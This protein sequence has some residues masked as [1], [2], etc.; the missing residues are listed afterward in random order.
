MH[1]KLSSNDTRLHGETSSRIILNGLDR[2]HP[3]RR[4]L[5]ELSSV[6]LSSFL[7]VVFLVIVFVV[8]HTAR[9]P[10]DL[11]HMSMLDLSVNLLA[12]QQRWDAV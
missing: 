10:C 6:H 5:D 4:I 8:E 1:V 2:V 7:L 12:Y 11:I 9:L 3:S